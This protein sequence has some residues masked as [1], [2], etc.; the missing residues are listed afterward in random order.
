MKYPKLVD[1]IDFI[2]AY[3]HV[4]LH[5]AI[6]D[7][8]VAF[9]HSSTSMSDSAPQTI[10]AGSTP[11]GDA[12]SKPESPPRTTA[13]DKRTSRNWR[14]YLTYNFMKPFA[15]RLVTPSEVQPAG[16]PELTPPSGVSSSCIVEHRVVADINVYDIT[17]RHP[18]TAEVK[19]KRIFYFCGGGWSGLPTPDHWKMC[20]HFVQELNRKHG[21]AVVSLVSYP[22]APNTPAPVALPM[23]Q[24]WYHEVFSIHA[25][26]DIIFAGDS[27]G[28][29]IALALPL[30]VLHTNL[31]TPCPIG[32]LAISPS[33]DLRH[34]HP[35]LE[36]LSKKDP[37]LSLDRINVTAT[38]WCGEWSRGDPRVSP[39][40]AELSV[41]R[42][43]NVIVSG[44]LGE[45]DV[46]SPEAEVFVDKLA[47]NRVRGR[48]LV[49]E[50]QMHC[51]PLMFSYKVVPEAVEAVK[52]IV[53]ELIGFTP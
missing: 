39:T 24:K 51:F 46:L 30:H 12:E 50:R 11:A 31:A 34:E 21:V 49:W 40:L 27:S 26:E 33:V 52:W 47:E 18:S 9:S 29:N 22:L 44:V 32:I 53:D 45:M 25:N 1:F 19:Q 41:L 7:S 20:A 3:S 4:S 15:E 36:A 28:G 8:I 43:R 10:S 35:D 13:I 17:S 16:S 5:D 23:L 14:T 37:L 48:W 42:E 6:S 2:S 38:G